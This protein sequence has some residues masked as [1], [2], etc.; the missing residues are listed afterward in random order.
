MPSSLFQQP[1]H[2]QGTASNSVTNKNVLASSK[3]GL[4]QSSLNAIEDQD[5]AMR[6]LQMEETNVRDRYQTIQM[7]QKNGVVDDV[8]RGNYE[9]LDADEGNV[10]R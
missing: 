7:G 1:F 9:S 2:T 3:T 4:V 5:E 8:N 6:I 10:R